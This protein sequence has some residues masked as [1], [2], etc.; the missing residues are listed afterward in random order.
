[1]KIIEVKINKDGDIAKQVGE[2]VADAIA[3]ENS[4]V[5]DT[6]IEADNLNRDE[7]QKMSETEEF[8]QFHSEIATKANEL[9]ELI[10]ANKPKYGR[11]IVLGVTFAHGAENNYGQA[12]CCGRGD[13][14]GASLQR[15]VEHSDLGDRLKRMII[16]SALLNK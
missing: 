16:R 15:I 5:D 3:N 9:I 6:V 14:V 11:S 10:D 7:M 12:A 2:A 1:M 13:S 8:Q 4:N